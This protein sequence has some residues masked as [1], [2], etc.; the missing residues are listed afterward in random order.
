MER[1]V[2]ETHVVCRNSEN[3]ERR[4]DGEFLSGWWDIAA[5]HL[6]PGVVFALHQTKPEGSYLA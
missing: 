6:Q 4:H 3:V 2:E 5:E 1:L